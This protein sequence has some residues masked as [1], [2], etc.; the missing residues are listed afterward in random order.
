[1]KKIS[2]YLAITA[3]TLLSLSTYS[4]QVAINEDG[5]L[6]NPHAIL[7]VKSFTKGVLI[8]RMSTSNR[9][10]IPNTKGLLVYDSTINAFFFNTGSLWQNLSAESTAA[11]DWSLTGNSGTTDS[12]FL[13]TIDNRPL[14]IRVGNLPSG[15]I[16]PNNANTAW[17]YKAGNGGAGSYNTIT[18]YQAMPINQ[19]ATHNTATGALAMQNTYLGSGNAGYGA[20][21]MLNNVSGSLNVSIGFYSMNTLA[22]GARNTGVGAYSDIGSIGNLNNAT[23]IGYGAF[24]N[25]SNKVR[26][27][28]AAVTVIEGQVPFTTP[29]DGR[30]KYD[31]QDDVKGLDFILKL[32]PVTYRFNVAQFDDHLRNRQNAKSRPPVDADIKTANTKASAVRRTGFIAQEVEKA[33]NSSGYDFGGL[34]KPKSGEDYYSISYESFIMPMVKAIQE[35]QQLITDLQKQLA[36]LKQ[37]LQRSK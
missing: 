24:V 2:S 19:T 7:D 8:P 21:S 26:I 4:Q 29:S 18:G 23:A 35:Q 12:N 14:L 20:L 34:L 30:F 33:A 11:P 32:R 5:S 9:L 25:Q 36:E 3:I 17:G 13:G 37:Q 1:M 15:R 27:G 6:P 16:D 28:N 22:S 10:A 31:V